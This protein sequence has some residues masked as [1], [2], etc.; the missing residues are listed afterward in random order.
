MVSVPS[1]R[2]RGGGA[3]ANLGKRAIDFFL[4]ADNCTF[5]D[6]MNPVFAKSS[7]RLVF[8]IS[9]SFPKS[10]KLLKQLEELIVGLV[11]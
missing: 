3:A 10:G 2:I 7:F 11:A 5:F 1:P 9:A 6:F 8:A 4:S